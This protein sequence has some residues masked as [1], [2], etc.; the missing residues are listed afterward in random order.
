MYYYLSYFWHGWKSQTVFTLSIPST[1]SRKQVGL[2]S[3]KGSIGPTSKMAASH[4]WKLV[5]AVGWEINWSCSS[6]LLNM[7]C[8]CDLSF[9]LPRPHSKSIYAKNHSSSASNN[10]WTLVTGHTW[11]YTH[12]RYKEKKRH[13]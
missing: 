10:L 5:L 12:C 1:T 9:I 7:A 8:T 6:E 13:H 4:G 2:K 11:L 3:S